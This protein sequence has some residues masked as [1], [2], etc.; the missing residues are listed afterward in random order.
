MFITLTSTDNQDFGVAAGEAVQQR[1]GPDVEVEQ[2]R[3]ASQLGEREP[4]PHKLWLVA[5]QKGSGVPL[6][7]L[8]MLGQRSG[9]SVA[10]FVSLAVR[11]RAVLKQ[12]EGL[13]W[14]FGD[15][16]Q[17]TFQ[18]A[19]KRFAPSELFYPAGNFD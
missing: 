1:F 9:R 13:L 12:H 15:S 3:H 16:V 5:Q 17:K 7:Q 6:L 10:F 8:S 11:V 4:H 2:R 18:N 14:L 19:V